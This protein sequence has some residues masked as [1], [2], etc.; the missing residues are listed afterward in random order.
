MS[1]FLSLID[2]NGIRTQDHLVPKRTLNHSA[3]LAILQTLPRNGIY[4]SEWC[5][6][7]D[8]AFRSKDASNPWRVTYFWNKSVFFFFK[9]LY[10]F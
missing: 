3:K 1:N 5:S 8:F 2:S 10:S 4:S 9:I 6:Y 7:M